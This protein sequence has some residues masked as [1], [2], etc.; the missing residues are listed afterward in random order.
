MLWKIAFFFAL[1]NIASQMQR[2][3][4]KFEISARNDF[5]HKF[6]VVKFRMQHIFIFGKRK[7]RTLNIAILYANDFCIAEHFACNSS[8]EQNDTSSRLTYCI[9]LENTICPWRL[10]DGCT[11]L[12]FIK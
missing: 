10:K 3:P 5:S 12:Y 7:V 2:G 1:Q 9:F 11:R 6:C 8:R 4:G